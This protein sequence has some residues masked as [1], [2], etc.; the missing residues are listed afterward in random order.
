LRKKKIRLF[1]LVELLAAMV[2]IAILVGLASKGVQFANTMSGESA[3]KATIEIVNR[4]FDRFKEKNGFYPNQTG[5]GDDLKLD[6]AL[7][8][9][10][11]NGS[12]PTE[13]E[14][15]DFI[16]QYIPNYSEMIE[17]GRIYVHTPTGGI[18]SAYLL[19]GFGEQYRYRCPGKHNVSSYDLWSMGIDAKTSDDG[20]E[21]NKE[22]DFDNIKNWE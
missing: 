12:D 3:T 4:Y 7:H 13:K 18:V 1:T 20:D 22:D 16:R 2:I 10:Q 14:L 21:E 17:S 19:D 11:L 15:R 6:F 5:A 8:Y 9:K